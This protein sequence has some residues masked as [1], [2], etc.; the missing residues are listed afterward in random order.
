[1]KMTENQFHVTF[2]DDIAIDIAENVLLVQWVEVYMEHFNQ[3]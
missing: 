1:M 3:S 2:A